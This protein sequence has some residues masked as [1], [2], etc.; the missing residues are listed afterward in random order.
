MPANRALPFRQLEAKFCA[1]LAENMLAGQH[2]RLYN[3]MSANDAF[4][5]DFDI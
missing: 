3:K 5:L 2:A 4:R 1:A